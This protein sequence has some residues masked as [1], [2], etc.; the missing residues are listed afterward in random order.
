MGGVVGF[1][2]LSKWTS[3]K[4]SLEMW[5]KEQLYEPHTSQTCENNTDGHER[6][7]G[8]CP[9]S[10]LPQLEDKYLD[11]VLFSWSHPSGPAPG[12]FNGWQDKW[13]KEGMKWLRK[14]EGTREREREIY[15]LI[16]GDGVSVV[17]GLSKVCPRKRRKLL[18]RLVPDSWSWSWSWSSW[19]FL[20]LECADLWP[21]TPVTVTTIT[22]LQSHCWIK[23]YLKKSLMQAVF[24][25]LRL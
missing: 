7:D 11:V 13:A 5:E 4:S 8:T 21:L 25:T 24:H 18:S 12:L 20:C 14:D 2:Q 10:L 22:Q 16:V 3:W 1:K 23:I 9:R 17:L 19:L 6:P 15:K